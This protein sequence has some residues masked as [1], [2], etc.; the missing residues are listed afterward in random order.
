MPQTDSFTQMLNSI[1]SGFA[2]FLVGQPRLVYQ[3]GFADRN[4]GPVVDVFHLGPMHVTTTNAIPVSDEMMDMIPASAALPNGAARFTI[5]RPASIPSAT[6]G[7]GPA[8]HPF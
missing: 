4:L 8:V 1:G 3:A 6:I 7:I 2:Q 5:R